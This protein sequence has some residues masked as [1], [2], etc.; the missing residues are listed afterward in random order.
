MTGY[1]SGIDK[2]GTLTETVLVVAITI[3][4]SSLVIETAFRV[5][6]WFWET[7]LSETYRQGESSAPDFD[8]GRYFRDGK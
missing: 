2:G 7:A 4:L 3:I 1:S 6:H 8:Q 5:Y